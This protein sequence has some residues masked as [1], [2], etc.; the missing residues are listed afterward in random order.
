MI[1]FMIQRL[2]KQD[3]LQ[4]NITYSFISDNSLQSR[5]SQETK[6]Q[7]VYNRVDAVEGMDGVFPS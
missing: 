4:V 5:D 1:C 3:M 2:I 6:W 7:W